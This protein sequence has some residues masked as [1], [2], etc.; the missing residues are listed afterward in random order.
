MLRSMLNWAAYNLWLAL[1]YRDAT[2]AR[3]ARAAQMVVAASEALPHVL[4]S[5]DRWARLLE[6][7]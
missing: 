6:P 3:R 7:T 2:P 5:I 1:G 4:R